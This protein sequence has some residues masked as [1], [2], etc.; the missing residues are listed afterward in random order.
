M[1]VPFQPPVIVSAVKSLGFLVMGRGVAAL[2]TQHK[3]DALP[4]GSPQLNSLFLQVAPNRSSFLV[5]RK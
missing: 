1:W 5:Q 4:I 3:T 2:Q